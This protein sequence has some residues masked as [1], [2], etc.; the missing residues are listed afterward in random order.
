M[1]E[2]GLSYR[3]NIF[4]HSHH[5]LCIFMNDEQEP[6]CCSHKNLHQQRQ[7][8][9]TVTTAETHYPPPHCAHVHCFLFSVYL[10]IYIFL[11]GG[12][13]LH[14]FAP[15]G[16]PWQTPFFLTAPK[17]PSV[18]WETKCNGTLVG[19]FS[20]YFH[21]IKICLWHHASTQ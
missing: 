21:T 4:Q 6:A 14:N 2:Q 8:T 15:Y 12:I 3:K 9:V 11:H 1:I 18:T 16:F 17:L 13:H 10:F 7:T 20:L 5:Q 19:R